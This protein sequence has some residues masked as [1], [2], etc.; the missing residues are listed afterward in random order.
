MKYTQE[1]FIAAL[2]V[3]SPHE[4]FFDG[5]EQS[6]AEYNSK[7]AFF[8]EDGFVSALQEQ[9][10]FLEEKYSFVMRELQRVRENE[11]AAGYS[12]L[13]YKMLLRN[14]GKPRITLAERPLFDDVGLTV[15]FEMA[16][17]FSLLA[18]APDMISSHKKRGLPDKVIA[19]TLEDCFEG[20]IKLRGVTHGRDGFDDKTYFAWNQLYTDCTIIRIGVLNF[21]MKHKFGKQVKVF[22][23]DLGEYKILSLDREIAEDGYV[24]GSAGYPDAVFVAEYTETDNEYIGYPVDMSRARVSD[25]KIALRR[26]E[27]REVLSEGDGVVSVHIPTG[28]S[29]TEENCVAA[30]RECFRIAREFYS[31]MGIKALFCGSWLLDPNIENLIK[32]KSNIVNFGSQYLRYPIKSGGRAVFSFLFRRPFERLEDLPENTSLERAVKKHYLDGKYVYEVAGVIF[33][34][35]LG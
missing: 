14:V 4:T 18:F 27:W 3:T 7:G 24:A 12:Y 29:I 23:N 19:D 10:H 8:L 20:T 6:M 13:L 33:E 16:A 11:L 1:D 21:E 9:W 35:M 26:D 34:D 30:Y 28:V 2:G 15:D 17:Y 32:K 22:K 5:Y 25:E 31:E